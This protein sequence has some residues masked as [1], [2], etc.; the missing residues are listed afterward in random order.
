MMLSV[1]DYYIYWMNCKFNP[2][3]NKTGN[4]FFKIIFSVDP[5]NGHLISVDPFYSPEILKTQKLDYKKP[6]EKKSKETIEAVPKDDIPAIEERVKFVDLYKYRETD[7]DFY[8]QIISETLELC[9]DDLISAFIS[10]TFKL[11][12][13]DK[14][15]DFIEKKKF[16]GKVLI[17]IRDEIKKAK[18]VED[19]DDKDTDKKPKKDD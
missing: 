14:A 16:T 10:G 1:R 6:S 19:K 3:F 7:V 8:R 13:L 18:V 4:L 2:F 12:E 15:I 17:E 9:E 11:S 5:I